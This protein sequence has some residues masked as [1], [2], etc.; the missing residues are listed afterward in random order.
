MCSGCRGR[1]GAIDEES[2]AWVGVV[3]VDVMHAVRVVSD[4]ADIETEV[5]SSGDGVGVRWFGSHVSAGCVIRV[6]ADFNDVVE[7]LDLD[8]YGGGV[9]VG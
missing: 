5:S 8:P 1:R 3:E 6:P 7:A 2:A 9:W 4:V